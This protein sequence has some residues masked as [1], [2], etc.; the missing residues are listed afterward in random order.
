MV[1]ETRENFAVA[2]GIGALENQDSFEGS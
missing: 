1:E 2:N